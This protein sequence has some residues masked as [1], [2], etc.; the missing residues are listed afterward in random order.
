MLKLPN[1]FDLSPMLK[2]VATIGLA[3]LLYLWGQSNGYHD[4]YKTK[5]D[6]YQQTFNLALAKQNKEFAAKVSEAINIA[7]K[8]RHD[9][10]QSDKERVRIQTEIVKVIEYVDREIEVPGD[11]TDFARNVNRVLVNATSNFTPTP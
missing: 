11:C 8:D 5:T 6:E 2:L 1:S 3:A 7:A 10:V 9:A 4:G